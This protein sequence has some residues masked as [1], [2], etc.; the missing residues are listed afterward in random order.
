MLKT[1]KYVL[2]FLLVIL[3]SVGRL[4]SQKH[5]Y[6]VHRAGKAIGEV[7]TSLSESDHT[8]TYKIIS[9][10][11]F[12]VLWRRYNRRTSNLVVYEN[13]AV[14]TSFLGVY[15]NNDLEDSSSI[16]LDQNKYNCY[17]YPDDRFVLNNTEVLFTTA[18]LYF[19]EPV[20]IQSIYSERFLQYCPLEPKGNHKYQLNLPNGRVNYYT[21]GDDEL[22]EILV[23]RTWF[24]LEIRQK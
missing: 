14:K 16:N 5:T 9:D 23:D 2:L 21:Y 18:K 24:N 1:R 12:K 15:M 20:G 6:T 8:K 11:N 10:V 3:I 22:I 7:T 17:R 4:Y 13:E 19:Q